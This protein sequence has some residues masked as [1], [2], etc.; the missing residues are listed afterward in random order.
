VSDEVG[1]QAGVIDVS[2][3]D[4]EIVY[5][6]PT[7]ELALAIG[8]LAELSWRTVSRCGGLGIEP[9]G[10]EVAGFGQGAPADVEMVRLEVVDP[11]TDEVIR[12][13]DLMPSVTSM[14][15]TSDGTPPT[16][17]RVRLV[18]YTTMGR[19]RVIDWVQMSFT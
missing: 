7:T 9:L 16:T 3:N 13:D 18:Q 14:Q 15:Y 1:V 8:D 12:V 5:Q 17:M 2:V 19:R 11:D 10:Y 6:R 4:G